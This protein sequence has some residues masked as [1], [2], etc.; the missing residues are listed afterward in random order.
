VVYR[1]GDQIGAWATSAMQFFG[2]TTSMEALV[3]I[4]LS[5]LWLVV[6]RWLG[7]QQE[8]KAAAT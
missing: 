7:R 8:K 5:A 1:M 4:P 2:F 3:A 6:G